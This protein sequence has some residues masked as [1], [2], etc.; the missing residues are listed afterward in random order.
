MSRVFC[1]SEE[2]TF[3]CRCD[4]DMQ[5]RGSFL[6][7][8]NALLQE[9]CAAALWLHFEIVKLA[10]PTETGHIFRHI[11]NDLMGSS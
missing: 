2:E 9:M 8:P 4:P 3:R 11:M 7:Q 10:C 1:V 5:V 6:G